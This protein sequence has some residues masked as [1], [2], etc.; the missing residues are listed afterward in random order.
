MAHGWWDKHYSSLRVDER[1]MADFVD[2][3]YPKS[4]PQITTKVA[5]ANYAQFH[6][7]RRLLATFFDR[8]QSRV[9]SKRLTA[10]VG[11]V[12]RDVVLLSWLEL[13]LARSVGDR[14]IAGQKAKSGKQGLF[15][16]GMYLFQR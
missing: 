15:E 8:W 4:D 16:Y 13:A 1:N 7:T 12:G 2:A 6:E 10:V 9:K 14:K 5:P 11:H 3:V